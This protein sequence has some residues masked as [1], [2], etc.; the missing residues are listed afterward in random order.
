MCACLLPLQLLFQSIVDVKNWAHGLELAEEAF[1][2]LPANH[3]NL[4][5]P[6]RVLFMSRLG[7]VRVAVWM[8][9]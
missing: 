7:Q 2:V 1:Q 3:A 4:L 5:W 9:V 8:C 6:D